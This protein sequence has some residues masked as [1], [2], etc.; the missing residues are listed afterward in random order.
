MMKQLLKSLTPSFM[1]RTKVSRPVSSLLI[2]DPLSLMERDAWI[3]QNGSDIGLKWRTKFRRGM[4]EHVGDL[5]SLTPDQL[6]TEMEAEALDMLSY[7]RELRRRVIS[8]NATKP[9]K[10]NESKQ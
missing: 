2:T 8:N 1:T 10:A 3:N 7:V 5:G 4:N 6:L 9:D